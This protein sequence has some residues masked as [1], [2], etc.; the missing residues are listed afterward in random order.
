MIIKIKQLPQFKHLNIT[1]LSSLKPRSLL[2][3]LFILS[4]L[5]FSNKIRANPASTDYVNQRVNA[6]ISMLQAQINAIPAGD[7]GPQGSPGAR[8]EQGIPGTYSA[9]EGITINDGVIQSTLIHHIGE[10]YQ[11]GIVFFVDTTGQHG[12]IAAKRDASEGSVAWQ[13]GESGEKIINA[14][15]N[16]ITAGET[17]TRLIIAEQTIDDQQ[18]LFA[19]LVAANFSTDATEQSCPAGSPATTTCYG[20]WYLPSLY[21]LNLMRL[22]LSLQ[23]LGDLTGTYWSS[24]E[25][26]VSEAWAEDFGTGEQI[27]IDKANTDL[28]VR[29]IR[30]F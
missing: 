6:A 7:R 28:R 20:G 9:G 23:G 18:G 27:R 12:L 2:P 30:S 8:G 19:A 15:G 11:G 25:A 24:T 4:S 22:H 21:E 1:L 10:H 17:N 13:N 29:P 16:G 3:A 14:Q 5:I 26:N